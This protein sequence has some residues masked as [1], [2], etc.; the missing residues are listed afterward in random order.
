MDQFVKRVLKVKHY[1][2]YVDDFYLMHSSR[3]FLLDCV[4]AIR[5]FLSSELSLTLHPKKIRLVPSWYGGKH[6]WRS[7]KRQPS[8]GQTG[9]RRR[10]LR[11]DM[12]P[13]LRCYGRGRR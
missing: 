13:L 2:R 11:R 5:E 12:R 4:G 1:G 10:W 6:N 7:S 3:G 8:L 9:R